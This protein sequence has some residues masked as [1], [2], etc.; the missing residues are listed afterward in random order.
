MDHSPA[1]YMGP[2]YVGGNEDNGDLL[3]K[4]PWMYCY[5]Q[6]PQPC[7]R[8]PWPMPLLE[9]PGHSWAS[10]D[11]Y[12]V[13]TLLF[14]PGSWCTQGSVCALQESVSKYCVSSGSSMMGLMV[15]SSKRAYAITKSA[16]PRT[17]AP[18]AVHCWPTSPQ[19]TLKHSSVTVGSLVCT[20]FAW[21]HWASLARMGFDS[22]CKFAPPT[23][24]L[25]LVLC[26]WT[27]DIFS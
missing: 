24:L 21:A 17:P 6:W 23:I 22:K 27:W 15:T 8:P 4:N 18:E 14:S 19:E 7:N 9:T 11:Q 1:I 26:H 5:T 25:G 20:R 13:G 10:L 12:L 16:V 3:Q 2:N